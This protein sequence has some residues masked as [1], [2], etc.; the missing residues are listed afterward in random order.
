MFQF[1]MLIRELGRRGVNILVLDIHQWSKA[2]LAGRG[3]M[4]R[5]NPRQD[6]TLQSP[7]QLHRS[8]ALNVNLESFTP[9]DLFYCIGRWQQPLL[10]H[11]LWTLAFMLVKTLG[12]ICQSNLN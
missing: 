5:G 3:G 2:N 6:Q 11:I 1:F 9:M 4:G 12:V 7:R 8:T 10:F